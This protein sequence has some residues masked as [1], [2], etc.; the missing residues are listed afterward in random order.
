MSVR[1]DLAPD[2]VKW[3]RDIGA[4]LDTLEPDEPELEELEDDEPPLI[5][6]DPV[7]TDTPDEDAHDAG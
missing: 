1:S 3:L 5:D 2:D 7:P 6:N 4:L